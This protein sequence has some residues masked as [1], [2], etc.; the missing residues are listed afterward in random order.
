MNMGILDLSACRFVGLD[1]DGVFVQDIAWSDYLR[2][3]QG[4][5]QARDE[6]PPLP[7]IPKFQHF[8][9]AIITGR[10]ASEAARTKAWLTK[11][12][13]GDVLLFCKPESYGVELVENAR[14]KADTIRTLGCTH[15]IESEAYQANLIAEAVPDVFVYHHHII[16]PNPATL[17]RT[18]RAKRYVEV[19]EQGPSPTY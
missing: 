5:L 15:Y 14:H 7:R 16:G 8:R 12:G 9:A 18:P 17:I 13:Y 2:D 6:L 19:D 4:T 3:Y 10:P 1:L 11:W